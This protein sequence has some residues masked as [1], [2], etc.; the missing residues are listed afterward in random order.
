MFLIVSK[1]KNS[2]LCE[3]DIENLILVITVCHHSQAPGWISAILGRYFFYPTHTLMINSYN[4]KW[5][6]L[7]VYTAGK[8][9]CVAVVKCLPV[10]NNS[11]DSSHMINDCLFVI[12]YLLFMTRSLLL[13][14][15]SSVEYIMNTGGR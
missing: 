11:V 5:T 1:K 6:F 3:D 9:D 10:L 2:Y 12:S 15:S 4:A 7:R 14:C 8:W 13:W